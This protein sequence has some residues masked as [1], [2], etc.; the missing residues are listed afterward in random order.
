MCVSVGDVHYKDLTE[1]IGKST[2]GP[3]VLVL[4]KRVPKIVAMNIVGEQLGEFGLWSSWKS[5][6]IAS[7]MGRICLRTHPCFH[8]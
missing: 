4:L 3:I 6:G 7:G 2:R 1:E 5:R 8:E